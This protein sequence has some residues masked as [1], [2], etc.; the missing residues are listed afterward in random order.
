MNTTEDG[1]RWFA[2]KCDAVRAMNA[3]LRRNPRESAAVRVV[4]PGGSWV[5][6]HVS[7]GYLTPRRLAS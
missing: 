1:V 3:Y 5:V 2:R 7:L 6:D 4:S